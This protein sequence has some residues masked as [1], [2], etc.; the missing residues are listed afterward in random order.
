MDA[1]ENREMP[2]GQN[3]G[4]PAL[5][6]RYPAD[7]LVIL[8]G[9]SGSGKS[10]FAAR[11]FGPSQVLSSDACRL[12]IADDA[13]TQEINDDTFALLSFWLDLR[14]KHR[15]FSVV[16]STALK[17]F[18][19]ENLARLARRHQVPCYV[20]ALDVPVEECVRRDAARAGRRVGERV[21]RRHHAQFEQ[22]KREI[23]RDKSLDGYHVLRPEAMETVVIEQGKAAAPDAARFD[24]IGDVHGCWPELCDLWDAL[25]YVWDQRASRV[26][27]PRHPE[28]RIPVFVGDLADRGPD[29]PRVLRTAA[30]LVAAGGARF[31]P[32]N[33]DDK[34]FRM[35]RG[36]NVQRTHG[37]DLTEQQL[38]ALPA[39]ERAALEKDV[40]THLAAQPPYL[41]LDDGRLVVAHAGIRE[42]MIGRKDGKVRE[43]TLYGD[44]RGFE[45]GTNKPIRHD[46]AQEYRGAALVVYGH[47]PQNELRWVHNTINID[48]GCVFG[49][50]LAALRYPER[51]LVTVPARAT[52]AERL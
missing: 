13:A 4:G 27:L 35:L 15:R 24:V 19:R 32:G 25:G 26:P 7:A 11:H 44:V 47:T 8:C 1:A 37:L 45:P 3:A 12:M 17:P 22:A 36:R 43:F 16:D 52:Y 31:V 42:E 5:T 2:G 29:S 20:L 10:T 40:L 23:A 6:I 33:H 38:A 49:G 18:A 50:F 9:P 51:E 39:E 34:L 28:G 48:G 14:L 41:V 21:V 46:W 30:S